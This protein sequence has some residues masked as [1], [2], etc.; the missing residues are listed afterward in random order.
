MA[1]LIKAREGYSQIDKQQ[2]PADR[3]PYTCRSSTQRQTFTSNIVACLCRTLSR[4]Q[5]NDN[6]ILSPLQ[7]ATEPDSERSA[8]EDA[9]DS[10]H[11]RFSLARQRMR[12]NQINV[13]VLGVHRR[14]QDGRACH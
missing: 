8:S 6:R 12:R 13:T 9:E 10:R 14:R 11:S 4:N 1:A 7:H 2:Y 3:H 5:P